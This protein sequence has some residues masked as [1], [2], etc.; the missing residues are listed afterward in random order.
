MVMV[1]LSCHGV[2][3][4]TMQI[5]GKTHA[6]ILPVFALVFKWILEGNWHYNNSIF[7]C[8]HSVCFHLHRSVISVTGF[9]ILSFWNAALNA[10]VYL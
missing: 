4:S 7:T 5:L 6:K 1:V 8:A 2:F 10:S 3:R 9:A